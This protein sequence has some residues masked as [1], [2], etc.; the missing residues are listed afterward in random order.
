[1]EEGEG[2][3]RRAPGIHP[4]GVLAEPVLRVDGRRDGF[5]VA[6]DYFRKQSPYLGEILQS[7]RRD[8]LRGPIASIGTGIET[9]VVVRLIHSN[10]LEIAAQPLNSA[11]HR[12]RALSV[13][14]L[15][16]HAASR[17]RRRSQRPE[18]Q[19]KRNVLT[20]QIPEDLLERA[21][22]ERPRRAGVDH[23][24]EHLKDL[25]VRRGHRPRR[26]GSEQVE[27]IHRPD[28]V[29]PSCRDDG[30]EPDRLGWRRGRLGGTNRSHQESGTK[31]S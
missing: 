17:W 11:G 6:H 5:D 21:I 9:S 16:T 10:V 22:G 29:I 31:S 20:A 3:A 13:E 1:M 23:L 24:R 7:V 28:E 14:A 15:D 12:K 27:V 8:L 18:F 30:A 4:G 26:A 19:S 2:R 25:N